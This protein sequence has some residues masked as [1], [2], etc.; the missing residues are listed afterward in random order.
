M[1]TYKF[2]NISMGWAVFAV[3]AVTYLM[4]LEATASFWDCGEFIATATKLDVGHPPG[5][6]FF[7]LLGK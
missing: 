7:M 4:T 3:A 5:A 1:K 2:L 6:P